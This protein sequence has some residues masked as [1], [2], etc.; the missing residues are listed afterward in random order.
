MKLLPWRRGPSRFQRA[1]DG[2]MSLIEHLLEL[3][4]RLFK[5]TV[6]VAIGMVIG[7]LVSQQVYEILERP[8]CNL[9]LPEWEG[10][11]PGLQQ[12]D[13]LTAFL[14][15][16]KIA[17]WVGLTLAA[18]VWFYQLW[19]FVAPGLHRHERKWAYI[20]VSIAV[21]LFIAGALLAYFV[22][23]RGLRFL[24]SEGIE[25][26][27]VNLEVNQYISFVMTVILVFAVGFELPLL[28]LMLN[29]AGVVSARKL[30]S[31]WRVAIMVATVF[32]ALTTP[33]PGP[34]GMILLASC[35]S[36]MYFAA[37]GVAFL[38]DRRRARRRTDLDDLGDDELSPL[39][40]ELEPVTAGESIDAVVAADTV[41]G[42][43]RRR[44][45]DGGPSAAGPAA[46]GTAGRRYDDLI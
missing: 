1:S 11:C 44:G 24:M 33:D 8:Y 35:L 31:W 34:F 27:S 23:E 25:G 32:A 10:T 15:M 12:L 30:L 21:P 4:S 42:G 38:N 28:V 19:A 40:E 20:F 17:L 7:Y 22:I 45:D 43:R 29:F 46:G 37:V 16:L 26:L 14:L 9:D 13:A 36:A 41:A 39:E 5:A 3:R 18:P 6:A 2:S